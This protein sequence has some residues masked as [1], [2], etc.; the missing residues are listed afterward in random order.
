MKLNKARFGACFLVYA[1]FLAA[2]LAALPNQASAQTSTVGGYNIDPTNQQAGSPNGEFVESTNGGYIR[3]VY[4]SN[5]ENSRDYYKQ[6]VDEYA[7]RGAQVIMV[8]NQ[9]SLWPAGEQITPQYVEKY[10]QEIRDVAGHMG[11]SVAAF[12]IWNE[13]DVAGAATSIYIPPQNYA[14]LL[15]AAYQGVNEASD[16]KVIVGGLV[17]GNSNY[18]RQ[19]AQV[20]SSQG[21]PLPADGIGLHPYINSVHGIRNMV[22][23]YLQYSQGRPLWIT[24]FGWQGDGFQPGQTTQS[25]KTLL[26]QAAFIQEAYEYFSS[27][28]SNQLASALWFAWSDA[29]L[30]G[31]GFF[32]R[33]GEP[34][35]L[36]N[37]QTLLEFFLAVGMG[38]RELPPD[39]DIEAF[40]RQFQFSYSS[41]FQCT[42]A[43]EQIMNV[44]PFDCPNGTC[45]L[46]IPN[47]TFSCATT[48]TVI[49]T[50]TYSS[51]TQINPNGQ[52]CSDG[53]YYLTGAQTT[54]GGTVTIDPSSAQIPFVGKS[55]VN[56]DGQVAIR[57]PIGTARIRPPQWISDLIGRVTGNLTEIGE[58]EAE[59]EDRMR[60]YLAEY[61]EGTLYGPGYH[62]SDYVESEL[63]SYN[64]LPLEVKNRSLLNEAGVYRKL[65]PYDVQNNLK[66]D[67]VQKAV[68]TKTTGST[69]DPIR[70]YTIRLDRKT[71]LPW[72]L[73]NIPF[74]QIP[75]NIITTAFDRAFRT[76]QAK[77]TE[78]EQNLPPSITEP[79]YWERFQDWRCAGGLGVNL[80]EF[81]L[82]DFCLV[83]GKFATLWKAVPMFSRE[84]T[85]G[86]VTLSAQGPGSSLTTLP[87]DISV[88]H[89]QRL[90]EATRN[91]S[92]LLTSKPFSGEVISTKS[93]PPDTATVKEQPNKTESLANTIVSK[94][95]SLFGKIKDRVVLAQSMP[96]ED[97]TQ[98][99]QVLQA[100]SDRTFS[101]Q[102]NARYESP[103]VVTDVYFVSQTCD[104]D[105]DLFLNSS[106]IA[107]TNSWNLGGGPFY[108]APQWNGSPFRITPGVPL[109]ITYSGTATKCE[110]IRASTTCTFTVDQ[111][112]NFNSTCGGAQIA[113]PICG[114]G[115]LYPVDKCNSPA[116]PGIGGD[117]LCCGPVSGDLTVVE[118]VPNPPAAST[119]SARTVQT[120]VQRDIEVRVQLPQLDETWDNTVFGDR[121]LFGQFNIKAA[122]EYD[123]IVAEDVPGES[124]PIPYTYS[125]GLEGVD[126]TQG[127]IKYPHLAAINDTKELVQKTL[128]PKSY[129]YTGAS[130]EPPTTVPRASITSEDIRAAMTNAASK[131]GVPVELLQAIFEIE[132]ID[133]LRNPDG[134]ECKRNSANAAGLAQV[135]DGTYLNV[136]LPSERYVDTSGRPND[137]GIYDQ[138]PGK[139]S[140][141]NPQDAFELMARVLLSKVYLLNRSNMTATQGISLSDTRTIYRASWKYYGSYIP[142]S[143]TR[144]YN[145]FPGLSE[146]EIARLKRGRLDS[147]TRLPPFGMNYADIVCMKLGQCPPYPHWSLDLV[148]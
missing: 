47:Q 25:D 84:D 32:D 139:L 17:S 135:V 60:H 63:A 14:A 92:M 144:G 11:S 31:F 145:Y 96:T 73:K 81:G 51:G 64:D 7:S 76:E 80:D 127:T 29:M 129:E 98:Q 110:P 6:I 8:F 69:S 50:I 42:S 57:T 101:I 62:Y 133:Y 97:S 28:P 111:A 22:E 35:H 140:R 148:R 13:Q 126:P 54:W 105:V 94:F 24:E 53:Q 43:N 58:T 52:L 112:G 20:F 74:L 2:I 89:T 91:T 30:D 128:H 107:G 103:N 27:L 147:F 59:S 109:T 19:V 37:G 118:V 82:F 106:H 34:K 143:A 9:E 108:W 117:E 120:S 85:L 79:D 12:E 55:Q 72:F 44:R 95:K 125:N 71:Q 10:K 100:A 68:A 86:R 46:S 124:N 141:C 93:T 4:K 36:P 146:T 39:F 56:R 99:P 137:I 113:Q 136:T 119:E 26:T 45:Y 104:G 65:A 83:R 90:F 66:K 116:D 15:S 114:Q 138:V 61:F 132:G 3:L 5:V 142:D 18:L 16:A 1:I 21:V 134:Y 77:L 70:D 121:A 131:Y 67:V 102:V 78:F 122:G 115:D 48:P 33:N 75:T 130:G 87:E 123:R 40:L 41:P 88:P 49:D 23:A 38:V